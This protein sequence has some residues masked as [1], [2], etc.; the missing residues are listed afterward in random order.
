MVTGAAC[1]LA[2]AATLGNDLVQPRLQL[3]DAKLRRLIQVLIFVVIGAAYVLALIQPSTI[4]YMILTAYGFTAQLFPVTLAALYSKRVTGKGAFA[5]VAAGFLVVLFFVFGPAAS[6]FGI[7]PG[8]LG[9]AANVPV[10]FLASAI[11]RT[12][13][14]LAAV[15]TK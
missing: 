1:S 13:S 14:E 4:V 2:A 8:I 15:S 3:P 6:P 10:M 7:H 5:G 12:T 11:S 9:L